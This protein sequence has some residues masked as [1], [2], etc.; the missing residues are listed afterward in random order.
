MKGLYLKAALAVTGLSVMLMAGEKPNL[1]TNGDFEG[2]KTL[3]WTLEVNES[4][5]AAATRELDSTSGTAHGGKIFHRVTVTAV[6]S[7][8]EEK[9]WHVQLKDPT[10]AAKIG[11][12]Y[13]FS[14]W[15]RCDA[16]NKAQISVYGKDGSY[17][18][19]ST[20]NLTTEWK[21][22]HMVYVADADGQQ[23]VNFAFVIGYAVGIYDI[24]DVVITEDAPTGNIYSNG[25]FEMD[26]AGWGFYVQG[27][28]GKAEMTIESTGAQSG[29]K[30]CRI[31]VTNKA[32]EDWQVQLSDGSWV[33]EMGAEYT[34]TFSV[35]SDV[36]TSIQVAVN[37]GASRNY[38]YVTSSSYTLGTE[39]TEYD[40]YF[41]VEEGADSLVGKDS[42]NFNFYCGAAV[43]K[44][45][46]D[47][48]KLVKAETSVKKPLAQLN[49][50]ASHFEVNILPS[51][52]QCGMPSGAIINKISIHDL[53]GKV[54][55][56]KYIRDIV[57]GNYNVP[58]PSSGSWII[59]VDADRAKMS[60]SIV[61]P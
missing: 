41:M 61:I 5:G 2:G 28:S 55:Y 15:A 16:E 39:W 12:S 4:D 38:G 45:D 21:Q 53:Q 44:I 14:M 6:S 19:S 24:D 13:H 31:N 50:A 49:K 46:I 27:D 48:V 35:K 26:A 18:T 57:T 23:A 60:R 47:N 40:F 56:S 59:K 8:P 25:D 51:Y 11:Y 36:E 37:A 30:F 42:L 32:E 33:S 54:F 9:N 20:L 17:K 7:A 34:F 58:R 43:A 10:Y 52:L 1:L 3:G 22:Y 29:E